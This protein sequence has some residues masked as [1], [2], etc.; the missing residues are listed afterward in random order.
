MTAA[1]LAWFVVILALAAIGLWSL[2][3]LAE[4]GIR[5]VCNSVER[6]I[7]AGRVPPP[8]PPP[9]MVVL[10]AR[11]TPEVVVTFWNGCA[12]HI[13]RTREEDRLALASGML[14]RFQ[15]HRRPSA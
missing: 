12:M 2:A 15:W 14:L 6:R 7:A 4:R 9:A 3:V 1:E 10:E 11:A 8:P 5:Y 13:D